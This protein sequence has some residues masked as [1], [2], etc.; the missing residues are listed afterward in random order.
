M[1]LLM[2]FLKDELKCKVNY[3]DLLDNECISYKSDICKYRIQFHIICH[4]HP[5][6]PITLYKNHAIISEYIQIEVNHVI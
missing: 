2:R 3:C 6:D 1:H 4:T 5:N